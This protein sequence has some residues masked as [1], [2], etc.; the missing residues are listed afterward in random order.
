LGFARWLSRRWLVSRHRDDAHYI[1]MTHAAFGNACFMWHAACCLLLLLLRLALVTSIRACYN[2]VQCTLAD[3]IIYCTILYQKGAGGMHLYYLAAIDSASD[4]SAPAAT[5]HALI[6][7]CFVA[8]T[9]VE[10]SAPSPSTAA[11]TTS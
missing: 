2:T 1:D 10:I 11:V 6:Q 3:T 5:V 7:F 4:P 9:L 8:S